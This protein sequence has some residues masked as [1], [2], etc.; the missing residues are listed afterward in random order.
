MYV[1]ISIQ[2]LLST[3]DEIKLYVLGWSVDQIRF[4]ALYSNLTRY[5]STVYDLRSDD[6]MFGLWFM[7]MLCELIPEVLCF[8]GLFYLPCCRS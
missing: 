2:Q 8:V 4:E 5:R 6:A 7:A 3:Y 1:S